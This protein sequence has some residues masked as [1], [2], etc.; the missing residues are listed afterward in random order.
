MMTYHIRGICPIDQES[1]WVTSYK[2]LFNTSWNI[3]LTIAYYTAYIYVPVLGLDTDWAFVDRDL[4]VTALFLVYLQKTKMIMSRRKDKS[5][6][7]PG[8]SE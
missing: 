8:N 6:L 1:Q 3:S 5:Q 2:A 4:L 7:P